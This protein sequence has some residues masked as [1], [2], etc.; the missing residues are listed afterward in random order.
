VWVSDGLDTQTHRRDADRFI[1]VQVY[2]LYVQQYS[3]LCVRNAQ[4]VGYNG[5]NRESLVGD[6]LV[7]S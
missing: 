2:E 3:D 7:L 5:E 1:L 4:S 6:C